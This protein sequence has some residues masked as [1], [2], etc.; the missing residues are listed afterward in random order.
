MILLIFG[1]T[2]IVGEKKEVKNGGIPRAPGNPVGQE[3]RK[4]LQ[5][6]T[7]NTN[8]TK[9]TAKMYLSFTRLM[10]DEDKNFGI[11]S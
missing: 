4:K 2:L 5:K 6:I 9:M 3:S 1:M 7:R 8:L 11:A 10:V